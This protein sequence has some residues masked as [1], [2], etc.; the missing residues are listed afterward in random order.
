MFVLL[1]WV[2]CL[3]FLWIIY[4]IIS[5]GQKGQL[6]TLKKQWFLEKMMSC[7]SALKI[8]K[9]CVQ[10][11]LYQVNQLTFCVSTDHWHFFVIIHIASI[12][13][14][15]LW[16]LFHIFPSCLLIYFQGFSYIFEVWILGQILR[17]ITLFCLMVTFL[18]YTTIQWVSSYYDQLDKGCSEPVWFTA[19]LLWFNLY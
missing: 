5:W 7:I 2:V 15:F 9:S 14:I 13:P 16:L 12:P 3:A 8:F 4:L 11:S 19:Q 17:P 10:H 1:N 6:R 18:S